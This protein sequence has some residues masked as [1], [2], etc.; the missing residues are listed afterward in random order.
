MFNSVYNVVYGCARGGGPCAGALFWQLLV[1]GMD[2]YRGGYEV[3]MSEQPS[4]ANIITLNSR[5][6]SGLDHGLVG[7]VK[8]VG[9]K[10]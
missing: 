4:T 1:E 6:I 10:N 5:Q 2:N 7:S 8:H 9:V 3:I